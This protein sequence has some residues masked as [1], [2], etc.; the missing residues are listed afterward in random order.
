MYAKIQPISTFNAIATQLFIGNVAVH[1][2]ASASLQWWLHQD[3]GSPLFTGTLELVGDEYNA[4]NDDA[5][6]FAVVGSKIGV[7]ILEIL[8]GG[9]KV[10]DTRTPHVQPDPHPADE[11]AMD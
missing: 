11:P 6:L 7:T 1:L 4:W 8:P 10:I 9:I 3:E 2:G 5:A